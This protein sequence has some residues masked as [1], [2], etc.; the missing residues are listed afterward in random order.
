[1]RQ[2]LILHLLL[3]CFSAVTSSQKTIVVLG[4]S[5]A[6]GGGS[7][8]NDSAWA[9]RLRDS[10]KKN[11]GDGADTNV[12]NLGFPGYVTY[13]I[14]ASNYATPSNRTTWLVDTER[15][16]TKALSLQP[17]IIII[18]MPSNDVFIAPDYSLK[19]T[20]DNFRSLYQQAT[21]AGVRCYITTTQPRNDGDPSHRLGLRQLRDSI[22]NNFGMFSINFWDDL[23]TQDGQNMLLDDRRA[24]N[25]HPNNFGHRLLYQRV[26]SKN[27]FAS[28]AAVPLPLKLNQFK[29]QLLNNKVVVSWRAEEQEPNTFF[30]IQRSSDAQQYETIFTRPAT[31]DLAAD[32]EWIDNAPLKGLSHYR[33]RIVEQGKTTYSKIV[34]VDAGNK[35]SITTL[36]VN[37]EQLHISLGESI[38][39]RII[40]NIV[41]S[42]GTV[43]RQNN[44]QTSN[45]NSILQVSLSGLPAGQYFLRLALPGGKTEVRSFSKGR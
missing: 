37:G 31:A 6:A 35:Q 14:L 28:A 11:T 36:Y 16:I 15:N 2:F 3:L 10:Y 39:G 17:Q 18:N 21:A 20:M 9:S 27:I 34:R 23:V 40:A 25:I 8:P 13:K 26:A 45:S 19:E 38:D 30:Y 5:T 24:D 22:I 12:I 41:N 44:L 1:M 7:S 33:L 4:S 43:V 29:A 32:Y 42:G